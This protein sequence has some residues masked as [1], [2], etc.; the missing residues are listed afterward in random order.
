ME[1]L[2]KMPVFSCQGKKLSLNEIQKRNI[3]SITIDYLSYPEQVRAPG[4][5]GFFGKKK[6]IQSVRQLVVCDKRGILLNYKPGNTSASIRFWDEKEWLKIKDYD[7]KTLEK[8]FVMTPIRPYGFIFKV[9]NLRAI[10][11]D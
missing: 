10:I 1:E 5:F 4:I 8:K 3:T 7:K 9:S 11:W 6:I 2:E